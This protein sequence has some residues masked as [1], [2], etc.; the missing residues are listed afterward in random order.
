MPTGLIREALSH[1]SKELVC[2]TRRLEVAGDHHPCWAP[3]VV[4]RVVGWRVTSMAGLEHHLLKLELGVNAT[5][6]GK[7]GTF[8]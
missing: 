7:S 2:R 6:L 1:S 5:D 8:R 3:G 4:L